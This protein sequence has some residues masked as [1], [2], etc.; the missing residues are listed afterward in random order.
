MKPIDFRG[1]GIG[2]VREIGK[3]VLAK[4][5]WCFIRSPFSCGIRLL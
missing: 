3:A 5:L 4:W 1:L 2:N